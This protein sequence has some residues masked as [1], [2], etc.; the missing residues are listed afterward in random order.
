MRFNLSKPF[1]TTITIFLL[2]IILHYTGI[3][4]PV[5]NLVL[6]ILAP[7]GSGFYSVGQKIQTFLKPEISAVD[8][9]KILA[10]RDRLIA[11]RAELL[12]LQRENEELRAS[13]DFKREKLYNSL[14]ANILGRDPNFSN[15]FILNKGAKDGVE[16]NLPVV[17]PEGILVG[18]ILKVEDRLS[19]M[20]IPTDTNFQTAAAILGESKNSTS[21]LVRGERGLGIKMEFIPQ[22]E[23]VQRDDIVITS[24]LE[25][26]MPK[27]LVIG[28]IAEVKRESRDIF[29]EATISPL[30]VYENLDTIMILLPSRE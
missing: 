12:T 10:E 13:L 24:G 11:E 16:I 7:V 8:Y 26:N 18:K 27:G 20:L 17:S 29:G 4:S 1:L 25:L 6:K 5:E 19:V 15:Y 2:L 3:F 9:E 22:E 14:A 28:K 21:G 23:E 30:A